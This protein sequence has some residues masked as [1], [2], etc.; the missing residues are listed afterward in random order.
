MR[1]IALYTWMQHELSVYVYVPLQYY[2]TYDIATAATL[3]YYHTSKLKTITTIQCLLLFHYKCI[4]LTKYEMIVT[5][6]VPGQAWS[7]P[8]HWYPYLSR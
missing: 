7:C 3:G 5:G 6:F 8:R 2:Y 1:Y 4:S